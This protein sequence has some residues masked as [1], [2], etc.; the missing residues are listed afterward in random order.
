MAGQ[1]INRGKGVRLVRVCLGTEPD[2][3]VRM[4]PV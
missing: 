2:E 1:I 3:S 4:R